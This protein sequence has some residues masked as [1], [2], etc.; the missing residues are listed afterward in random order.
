MLQG[1]T[2]LVRNAFLVWYEYPGGRW[3]TGKEPTEDGLSR[4]R[5]AE[6]MVPIRDG[7]KAQYGKETPA[8][9]PNQIE[10]GK[11]T[12]SPRCA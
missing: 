2:L 6:S 11:I 9:P 1:Q 12:A 10:M 5:L 3:E 4:T 8:Q 7:A